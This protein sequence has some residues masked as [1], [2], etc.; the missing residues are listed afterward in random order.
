V[1]KPNPVPGRDDGAAQNARGVSG[2]AVETVAP[3]PRRRFTAAEKLRI[4]KAAAAALA[5][6]ERGAL[7]ALL[8]REGIYSSHLSAWRQQFAATGSEG[9]APR[10]PGRTPKLS[11]TERE[12]L[13]LKKRNAQLEQKLKV[14]SAVIE[15]QKKAHAVLG[16]ALPT[17]DEEEI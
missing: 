11:E 1:P 14:A 9:L 17:L 8:R 13:A 16:I 5:S 12:L 2:S 4:L 6:G 15:L 10:K 3:K 7:E